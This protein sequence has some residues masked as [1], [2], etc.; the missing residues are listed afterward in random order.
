MI[1]CIKGFEFAQQRQIQETVN[2]KIFKKE[3]KDEISHI[4]NNYTKKSDDLSSKNINQ[5]P[6][7]SKDCP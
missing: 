5:S 4:Y 1:F 6:K 3:E 7:E 2:K